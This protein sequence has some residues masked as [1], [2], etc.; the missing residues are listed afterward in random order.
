MSPPNRDTPPND[1]LVTAAP[2]RL[3]AAKKMQKNEQ[4]CSRTIENERKSPKMV[5]N[6]VA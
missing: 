4:K 1:Y 3:R 5:A 2:I 6:G